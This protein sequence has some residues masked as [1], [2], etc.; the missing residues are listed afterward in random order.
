MNKYLS[1]TLIL[2]IQTVFSFSQSVTIKGHA[3]RSYLHSAHKIY[4]YVNDDFIS[5]HERELA[6]SLLDSSGNFNLTFP[7]TTT[8]H[9]YLT[10][11]N[12]KADM[13]TVPNHTYDVT[14]L[15]KDSDAV[16]TLT[17]FLPVELEFN[18]S[19][20]SEL[21][22]LIASFRARFEAFLEYHQGMIT[23]KNSA[24]FGKIDTMMM[25]CHRIYSPL[26][27]NYLNNLTEYT[28]A[29][30]EESIALL[31]HQTI[32]KKYIY[33]KRI[34]LSNYDYM[35]FFNQF[36]K[37]FIN[38]IIDTPPMQV[39]VN[40][41]QNFTSLMEYL[42]KMDFLSNDTIRETVLLKTL[43]L[44]ADNPAYKKK[45]VFA[46]L[47]QATILCKAKENRKA[48][49]NIMNRI[50]IMAVGKPLPETK[51]LTTEGDSIS[52][53][54]FK[55]KYLYINFWASWCQSCAA[56][57]SLIPDLKKEYG[58]KIMFISISVDKKVEDMNNFL[59][60]NPKFKP[61]RNRVFLYCDN[62]KQTKEDFKLLSVPTYYLADP[63]GIILKSP[64]ANPIDI[65]PLFNEI[66]RKRSQ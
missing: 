15:K 17:Q 1:I 44:C 26:K 52:L 56:E 61:D 10:V 45:A 6:N 47:Q 21:N 37:V 43:S 34:Q 8:Q 29:S 66:K 30:L 58:G 14:F 3:D 51:F 7:A 59:K 28:F 64:A 23:K 39:E 63:K 13:V 9:I 16:Y 19:N 2:F 33:G 35:L 48:A 50:F 62:F 38:S 27:N 4:A 53:D 11:D 41:K 31:G 55:G 12:A 5:T 36:F 32:Y 40:N 18:N 20:D 24:I 60:K 54:K 25:I 49:E 65:E 42:K 57:I 22:Y 46:I